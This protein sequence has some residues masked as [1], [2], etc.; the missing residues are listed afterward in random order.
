MFGGNLGV[1]V[2]YGKPSVRRQNL[3]CGLLGSSV[4]KSVNAQLHRSEELSI[5]LAGPERLNVGVGLG[6]LVC[7]RGILVL[8]A[9]PSHFDWERM[10]SLMRSDVP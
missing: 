10:S 9:V 3:R 5:L 6:K 7:S 4:L 8:S 1:I 2:G